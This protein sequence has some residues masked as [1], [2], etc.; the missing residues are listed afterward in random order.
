MVINCV[1]YQTRLNKSD[2]TSMLHA[3]FGTLFFKM[4]FLVERIAPRH[5]SSFLIPI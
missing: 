2:S 5:R 3:Q 1:K 4:D